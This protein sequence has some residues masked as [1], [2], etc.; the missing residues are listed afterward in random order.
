MLKLL[1]PYEKR[2]R[3]WQDE[4]YTLSCLTIEGGVIIWGGRRL[5]IKFLKQWRNQ[6]KMTLWNFRNLA[7]N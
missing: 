5:F 1:I 7:L 4:K 3:E 2:S 6:N